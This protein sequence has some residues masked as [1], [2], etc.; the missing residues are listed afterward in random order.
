MT[1]G[2]PNPGIP[3]DGMGDEAPEISIRKL[4]NAAGVKFVRVINPLN[5]EQVI[6]TYKEAL[7]FDGVAVIISKSPCT[8]IKGFNKK[9]PVKLEESN[10]TQ[11]RKCSDELACPAIS[12][13]D[14]K[15][16]L[17]E[18][19]CSGCNVCVQVCKYGAINAG[20]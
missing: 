17:D 5:L 1:G 3:V 10:C 13:K 4:A 7:E 11:C 19:M 16:V 6:K 20:R 2:Q 18:A 12:F 8:L 14:N 15:I 9:P